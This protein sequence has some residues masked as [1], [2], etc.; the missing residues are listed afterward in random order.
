[1][2]LTQIT[3]PGALWH[4]LSTA[5][6]LWFILAFAVS[7]TTNI[8][9]AIGLMGTTQLRL[10][11]WAT[12]EV[13]VGMSFSNL[14]IPL[15]GGAA[16]QIRFLQRQGANLATAIAAGGLLAAAGS[17][18]AQLPLFVIATAVTP[19]D[20]DI[21][22][23]SPIGSIELFL[24]IVS[25]LA[26]VAG[27]VFGVPRLRRLVMP[28]LHQG[29]ST[30]TAAVR[31]PRQLALLL[32]GNAG[33]AILYC[34][35]LLACLSSFGGSVSIWTLLSLSIGVR[36]LGAIV[37]IAGA[38]AAVST[39]GL[40]GALVAVGVDK[41]VA[42]ATALTNQLVVTYLPAIPGWLATRDLIGRDYL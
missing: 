7:M 28:S 21:A 29:L 18:V 2:L 41:N 37:P 40:S 36:A 9:F 19:A 27:F 3:A 33:A 20:F 30:V 39:I 17:V 1:V 5:N 38:G 8:A 15:V 24:G 23:V 26:I 16:M 22:N 25:I 11:L 14:A 13:Q 4:S 6:V 31:S 35:C 32:G 34:L 10:P 12:I 42:V